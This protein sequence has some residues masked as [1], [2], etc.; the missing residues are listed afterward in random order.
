MR[1]R[2]KSNVLEVEKMKK[3]RQRRPLSLIPWMSRMGNRM[4][5]RSAIT[6]AVR[7]RNR[8]SGGKAEICVHTHT[9]EL[10]D[11]DLLRKRTLRADL[12]LPA[13]R[14]SLAGPEELSVEETEGSDEGASQPH[15]AATPDG[16]RVDADDRKE[17]GESCGPYDCVKGHGHEVVGCDAI[18]P[19]EV[20]R[21][22]YVHEHG[23]NLDYQTGES[24][25]VNVSG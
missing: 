25:M 10:T 8:V 23:G 9:D 14:H 17:D 15:Q 18:K 20:R 6:S 21:V 24:E 19:G 1:E 5:V 2:D 3:R 7:A 13:V 16:I 11:G 4:R 12:V 22:F